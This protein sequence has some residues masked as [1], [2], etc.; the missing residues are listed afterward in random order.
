MI[1]VMTDSQT[2]EDE[3]ITDPTWIF[4]GSAEKVCCQVDTVGMVEYH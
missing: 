1:A 3:K 2:S 4:C